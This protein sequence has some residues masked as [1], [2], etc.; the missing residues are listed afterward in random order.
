MAMQ[1]KQAVIMDVNHS[2]VVNT[3]ASHRAVQLIHGHTHKPAT[4]ALTING[5]PATRFVLGEWGACSAEILACTSAGCDLSV[6][7]L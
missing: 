1:D 4:H 3:M 7:P 6:W 5:S 2:E